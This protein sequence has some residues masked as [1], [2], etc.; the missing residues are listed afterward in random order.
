MLGIGWLLFF[1]IRPGRDLWLMCA[2]VASTAVIIT[3]IFL[4]PPNARSY[5][6]PYFWLLIILAIQSNQKPLL[7]N[8]NWLKF[9]IFGQA[10]LSTLALIYGVIYFF[11]GA[12]WP[13]WRTSIMERSANGYQLMQWVDTVTPKDAVLNVVNRLIQS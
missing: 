2:I 11:P 13:S 9:P 10:F 5:L 4:A 7:N 1:T 12:L 8:Y 6:E 3:N